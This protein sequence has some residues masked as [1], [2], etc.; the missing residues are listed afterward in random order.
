MTATEKICKKCHEA[1]PL[2]EFGKNKERP[3]GLQSQCKP[4]LAAAKRAQYAADPEKHKARHREWAQANADHLREYK[5][6]YEQKNA[7]RRLAYFAAYRAANMEAM[8]ERNRRWREANREYLRAKGRAYAKANADRYRAAW[9][10]RRARIRSIGGGYTTAEWEALCAKYGHRCLR[11]GKSR[12]LTVDH[13]LPLSKGGG[14]VIGNLQPLCRS[15][16]CSKGTRH[17]DYRFTR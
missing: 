2:S 15:C 11:C 16:N 3:D 7:D 5:R 14:N 12:R 9:H 4:C 10:R 13:V 8:R 17:I 1:K 6:E